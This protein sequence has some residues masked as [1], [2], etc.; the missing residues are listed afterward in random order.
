MHHNSR[1]PI[2]DAYRYVDWLLTVPLLLLLASTVLPRADAWC[3]AEWNENYNA[4]SF[5]I[6]VMG[7]ATFFFWF[8]RQA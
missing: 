8:Q 2:N 5:G 6:A 1:T 7:S 4:L 3:Y